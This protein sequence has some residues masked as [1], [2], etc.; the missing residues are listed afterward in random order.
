MT[1]KNEM[2]K[3]VYFRNSDIPSGG[4]PVSDFDLLQPLLL[5]TSEIKCLQRD[6]GLWRVYVN[7]QVS[8]NKLLTE[9]F[10]YRNLS[11]NVYDTNPFSSGAKSPSDEII[12]ITVKG[13]PLSVDDQEIINMLQQHSVTLTSSIRHEKIRH[14]VTRKMTSVM[15]GNR[16]VYAKPLKNGTYLPRQSECA[17]IRCQIFHKGQPSN[18]REPK[19]T[20]C[21]GKHWLFQC[22]EQKKCRICLQEDHEPGSQLCSE[23]IENQEEV[24]SFAG[25]KNPLSNFYPCTI[26]VFGISHSSAEHAFQYVKA[27]RCGSI[28]KAQL[29]Q[30]SKTALDAKKLGKSIQP[31]DD[32]LEK[33]IGVM[34]EISKAKYDQV[35]SFRS[36]LEKHD[37]DTIFAEST[38]DDFW[39]TGLDR[40][41]TDH[42]NHLKWPGKNQ[43]GKIFTN[44]KKA[45]KR[46]QFH[47][48]RSQSETRTPTSTTQMNITEMLN[49]VQNPEKKKKKPSQNRTSPSPTTQR[50]TRNTRQTCD[51]KQQNRDGQSRQSRRDLFLNDKG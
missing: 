49:S 12:R 47:Q 51:S 1:D 10:E 3:P 46:E 24:V 6:R 18:K 17:G 39:G 35:E 50:S 37:V 23:Y 13:I 30:E 4:K 27:L 33:Q 48:S 38:Y 20:N 42:T 34:E 8:R 43:M 5:C 29:I 2:I 21:W 32:F 45:I 11:I 36:I 40:V 28:D 22:T 16:F 31:N 9:G 19:C 15:N 26:N 14:P 41:G 25:A 44:I 7:D